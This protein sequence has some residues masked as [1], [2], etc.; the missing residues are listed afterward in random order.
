MKTRYLIATALTI[1]SLN[2]AAKEW[3]EVTIA[4]D[5]T[6]P[7]FESVAPD[8]KLVG[9]EV[10]LSNALCEQLKLK[11]KLVNTAFDA[12]IPGLVSKKSDALITSLNINDDRKRL[13][14]FTEP[15]Y[16]ME[17]RFVQKKGA[18]TVVSPEGLK[19]KT[20]AVQAGTAQASYVRKV[21]GNVANVKYYQG[22][23]EPYLELLGGR[24]DLHFGFVV[25]VNDSF[26]SKDGK[27]YEFVGP[28][29][30]GKDDKSLG[31]GVAVAVRKGDPELKELFNQGL[32]AL[33]KNGTLKKINDKYFPFTL[34]VD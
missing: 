15:Y 26:L 27:D 13:I 33:R 6:Y 3:K 29:L 34:V 1:L 25:Q 9:F 14:D 16:R 12:L 28:S 24:A 21:Y 10:D 7:P 23:S 11:C 22:A 19:G 18:T 4:M 31:E 2:A 8:G 5:A 32:Q 17:N 30:S 20:I